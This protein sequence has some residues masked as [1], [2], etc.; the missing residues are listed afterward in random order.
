[1]FDNYYITV[2]QNYITINFNFWYWFWV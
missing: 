2:I 1:M